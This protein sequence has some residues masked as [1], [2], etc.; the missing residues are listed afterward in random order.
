MISLLQLS[1]YEIREIGRIWNVLKEPQHSSSSSSLKNS[2]VMGIGF[3]FGVFYK[4]F[5]TVAVFLVLLV[6]GFALKQVLSGQ[7]NSLLSF[8]D[9]HKTSDIM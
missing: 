1:T 7:L 8:T 9:S 4:K 6:F 5:S 2:F 3:A